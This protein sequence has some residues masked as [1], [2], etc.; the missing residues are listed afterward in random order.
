M[1]PNPSHLVQIVMISSQK[2]V[3]LSR[4]IRKNYGF[5]PNIASYKNIHYKAE[6][7]YFNSTLLIVCND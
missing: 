3:T 5:L 7:V 4:N 1:L 6:I 2:H